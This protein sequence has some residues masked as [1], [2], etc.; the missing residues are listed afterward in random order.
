MVKAGDNNQKTV[1]G[2]LLMLKVAPTAVLSFNEVL[3][4]VAIEKRFANSRLGISVELGIPL[5]FNTLSGYTGE[6]KYPGGVRKHLHF[7]GRLRADLRYYY[8]PLKKWNAYIGADGWVRK[9][10]FELNNGSYINNTYYYYY[11]SA[12][13]DKTVYG[14]SVIT[15]VQAPLSKRILL[16][17]QG[18]IGAAFIAIQRS[19]VTDLERHYGTLLNWGVGMGEDRFEHAGTAIFLPW[20]IR[21]CYKL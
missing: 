19:N 3:L 7:D 2:N 4:P 8:I 16:E 21:L 12:N 5:F 20:A 6:R 17:L 1:E 11:A 18:G 10:Q 15:G 13:M 14:T 9:Q